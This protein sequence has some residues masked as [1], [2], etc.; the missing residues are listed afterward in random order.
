MITSDPATVLKCKFIE[1]KALWD[2]AGNASSYEHTG[3][4]RPDVKGAG[5]SAVPLNPHPLLS[6]ICKYLHEETKEIAGVSMPYYSTGVPPPKIPI[7]QSRIFDGTRRITNS[8]EG[9]ERVTTT[10]SSG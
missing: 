1:W 4:R 7:F 6:A 10:E 8:L 2:T 3:R 9:N 5:T